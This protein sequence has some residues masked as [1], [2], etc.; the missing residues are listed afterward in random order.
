MD[1]LKRPSEKETKTFNKI[2][3]INRNNKGAKPLVMAA[4]SINLAL[5]AIMTNNIYQAKFCTYLTVIYYEDL[6]FMYIGSG[7]TKDVLSGKYKGS[8]TSKQYKNIFNK[9]KKESPHLIHSEIINQFESREEA[10]AEEIKLHAMYD[11][12]KCPVFMNKARQ[13]STRFTTDKHSDETK[14]KLS[15]AKK[16]KPNGMSGK[17]HSDETKAKIRAAQKNARNKPE[18]IAKM[19]AAQKGKT[20]S[21][22]TK[23]KMSASRK[24][25]NNGMSGK[26]H[27]DETKAKISAALKGKPQPKKI[28]TCPHCGKSGGVNVMHLWHFDKCKFKKETHF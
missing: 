16:G 13:T 18:V 4:P 2:K 3:E 25:E 27:P 5:E 17:T 28:V 23:A 21:D 6:P 14:A 22:E 19:S 20:H 7:K 24:G 11:V 1:I 8:V 10:F 15:A 12:A 26:T 9:L